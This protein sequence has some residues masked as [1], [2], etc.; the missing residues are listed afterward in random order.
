MR[1][2]FR[3]VVRTISGAALLALCQCSFLVDLGSLDRPGRA[4]GGDDGEDS[5][6]DGQAQDETDDV[7]VGDDGDDVGPG[8]ADDAGT[9]ATSDAAFADATPDIDDASD[10]RAV[11]VGPDAAADVVTKD[12][13]PDAGAFDATVDSGTEAGSGDA[14][15]GDASVDGSNIADLV[16]FYPFSETSGLVSADLSGNNQTATMQGATFAAGLH[17]DAAT[18]DGTTQ[19]VSLPA[20]IVTGLTAFS[21]ST[22]VYLNAALKHSHVFDFGTGTTTYM[23]LTPANGS[24]KLQF[25]ITTTGVAGEQTLNAT[26]ALGIGGWQHVCVT[27]AGA[28][29]TLYVNGAQVAQNTAMTL[30]PSNLGTTSNNWLGR[31]QFTTDPYLNGKIDNF[32]IYSRALS[33]TEVQQLYQQQL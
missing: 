3:R 5:P 16:A 13:N 32:R 28:T 11:Q 24:T 30:N 23:F 6:I 19:Y 17:D 14:G 31:S 7:V 20:G 18:M 27:L 12:A 8:E 33:A 4:A 25:A 10:Q 15:H 29:G 26:T 22:W 21:V 9:N 2:A 1:A